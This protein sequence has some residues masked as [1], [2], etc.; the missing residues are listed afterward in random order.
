MLTHPI[1]IFYS[2]IF[3]ESIPIHNNIL[4]ALVPDAQQIQYGRYCES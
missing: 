4:V 2:C 1:L 3:E